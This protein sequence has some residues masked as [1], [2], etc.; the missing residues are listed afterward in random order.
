MA[1]L[2]SAGAAPPEFE[3]RYDAQFHPGPIS[4]RAYVMLGPAL[5]I[6]E[7][8]VGPDWFRPQ[9]FFAV[10][11]TDWEPGRP[12][13]VG[14]DAIGFPGPLDTLKPGTYRA[15]AV[16]RLNPD[17]HR[18]GDGEGN[19]YGPVVTFRVGPEAGGVVKLAVDTIVPPKPFPET[20]RLKLVDIPSPIL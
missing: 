9:P 17:T 10:E 5:A 8:R 14:K 3:I 15:Q 20:D 1:A 13:A 12:L 11:A 19:A 6:G 2:S 7:P 18:L 4:A 16:V